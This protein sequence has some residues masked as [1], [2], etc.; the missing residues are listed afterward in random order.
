MPAF[1]KQTAK[2]PDPSWKR[3]LAFSPFS[4][5]KDHIPEVG[6]MV[7]KPIKTIGKRT[8]ERL[9]A[10]GSETELFARV[11][12][13]NPHFCVVCGEPVFEPL[14]ECFSHRIGK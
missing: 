6:K 1:P 14:A 13:E 12:A 11:W 3:A 10:H 2:M 7:R 5:P 8:K 9:A 4:K